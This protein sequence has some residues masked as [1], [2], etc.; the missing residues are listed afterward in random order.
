[1]ID[2]TEEFRRKLQANINNNP[3]ER[4]ELETKYGTVWNTNELYRDFEVKSFLAPFVLV[5]RKTDG[6]KGS[7]MFQHYPRYYFSFQESLT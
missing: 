5:K 6:K 2:D 1:M 4:S 7:L 3:P